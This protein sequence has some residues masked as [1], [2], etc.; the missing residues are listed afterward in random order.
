MWN[1]FTVDNAEGE[2]NLVTKSVSVLYS[3]ESKAFVSGA[4]NAQDYVI[5]HGGHRLVPNQKVYV[6]PIPFP[7]SGDALELVNL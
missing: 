4:L 1:L 2:Q 3:D 5:A 7:K 6:K